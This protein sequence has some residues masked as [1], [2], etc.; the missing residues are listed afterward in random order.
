[1]STYTLDATLGFMRIPGRLIPSY[2]QAGSL[3]DAWI[4]RSLIG[5]G[6][7]S[8]APLASGGFCVVVD[9]ERS[10]HHQALRDLEQALSQFG[11]SFAQAEITQVVQ[12]TAEWALE[13]GGSGALAGSATKRIEGLVVGA[14]A[15]VVGGLVMAHL[16]KTVFHH[17]A[18]KQYDGTWIIRQL[19]P[20]SAAQQVAPVWS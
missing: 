8:V 4:R 19:P 16:D 15:G 18:M 7:A 5:A 10:D 13:L 14:L 20:P 17:H 1:M 12:Q 3:Q 2:V 9:L 6:R 11:Y